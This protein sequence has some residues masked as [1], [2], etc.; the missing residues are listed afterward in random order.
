MSVADSKDGSKC[1][2]F[3]VDS[4]ITDSQ[5]D[6]PAPK[7]PNQARPRT[8]SDD[9]GILEKLGRLF[10]SHACP[11]VRKGQLPNC[12]IEPSDMLA[13]GQGDSS[14]DLAD[15]LIQAWSAQPIE[16]RKLWR[17]LASVF[18]VRYMGIALLAALAS[19][20]KV[21]S[22][23]VLGQF[24]RFLQSPDA[25]TLDG[26]VLG[27]VLVACMLIF[28]LIESHFVYRSTH[29]GINARVSVLSMMYAHLL[30]LNLAALPTAGHT[31]NIISNDAQRIEDGGPFVLFLI[32]APLE[33]L[34]VFGI[35]WSFLGPA[36]LAA[37]GAMMLIIVFLSSNARF[38]KRLR[39]HIVAAR[40]QRIKILSDMIK[41]IE[42]VKL[43]AWEQPFAKRVMEFRNQEM[44][45]LK[46]WYL[47]KS[48]NSAFFWS[49]PGC[50]ALAGF[51]VWFFA[52][53]KPLTSQLLFTTL[54]LFNSVR[55]NMGWRILR[56][57]EILADLKVSLN[58]I[59]EFLAIQPCDNEKQVDQVCRASTSP[60]HDAP[61]VSLRNASFSW[62]RNA[63][64]LS[65]IS[66][67]LRRGDFLGLI[68]PV[69][70][71]KSSLQ[72]ALL[73]HL[74]LVSPPGSVTITNRLSYAPQSPFIFAGTVRENILMG[75]P[76]DTDRLMAVVGVCQLEA[77]LTRW[78]AGLDTKLGDH[79]VKASGGQRARLA[80]AR[81]VYQDAEL[82]VLDDIFSA[83]DAAVANRIY[84][85]LSRYLAGRTVIL[86]SHQLSLIRR[87]PSVAYLNHGRIVSLGTFEQ[88]V[89]D[90]TAKDPDFAA[91]LAEYSSS[92]PPDHTAG[93]CHGP[94]HSRDEVDID[95]DSGVDDAMEWEET[96]AT[97]GDVTVFTRFIKMGG[98]TWL[99]AASIMLGFATSAFQA[100]AD[101]FLSQWSTVPAE[102]QGA[103]VHWMLFAAITV[104]VPIAAWLS[105]KGLFA[106]ILTT[107][108]S[109]FGKMLDNVM[110]ASPRFFLTR[111]SGTI[112]NRFSRDMAMIDE[113][114]PE[115]WSEVIRLWL[116]ILVIIVTVAIAVPHILL[117]VFPVVVIFLYLRARYVAANRQIRRL[118]ALSRS[119]VYSHLMLTVE[120][121]TTVTAMQRQE[122]YFERF[123]SLVDANT[124][125]LL[126]FFSVERWLCMRVDMLACLVIASA[127][128]LM[129]GLKSQL[130]IGLASLAQ[131]YVLSLVDETQYA[132]RKTAE[133]ELQFVSVERI[134]EY[135]EDIAL[136][137]SQES[138]PGKQPPANWPG[139]GV[140]EFRNMSL[141]YEGSDRPALEQI[142]FKTLPGESVGLCGRTGS[143]KSST[144]NALFRMA[145]P[146][147]RGSIIV[148][149]V[150]ICEI[151][152]HD[153]RKS[154]AI[155]PQSVF[156]FAG[157]VRFNLDPFDIHSE[158]ELWH[159]LELVEL[160][161]VVGRLPRKLDNVPA[162]S[163]GQGQLLQLARVILRKSKVVVLD[164]C[165]SNIDVA[166][167]RVLQRVIR[168][169]FADCTMLT[170]AHRCDT[171]V[172]ADRILMLDQGRILET[173]LPM[174]LLRNPDSAFHALA[175]QSLGK[176]K[177]AHHIS[178]VEAFD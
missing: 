73:G 103:S 66:L 89:Q 69:G 120:G 50:M 42:M 27:T 144:I 130:G 17:A 132:V 93:G 161:D 174:E 18:G 41:S 61:V 21:T 145:E 45:K 54:L 165:S 68:G 51:F 136:E 135:A 79:G 22:A 30:N 5:T 29:I 107:S 55:I 100:V 158:Q 175:R 19:S 95:G 125:S 10:F 4:V 72:L 24:I 8:Y 160:K 163:T 146:S 90:A 96:A 176:D 102:R 139:Q 170:I 83:L 26:I 63:P 13:L 2:L 155:I 14:R 74:H 6:D 3:V 40:D 101:F 20:C 77:D 91:V 153:L 122:M 28:A 110:R 113:L 70:S 86:V 147:P 47:F 169:N 141:T 71:G 9:R 64:V 134:L 151:G 128:G 82:Y 131:M 138:E 33:S 119:P 16:N 44:V 31:L 117:A 32:L 75:A 152:L 12:M 157:S 143:G 129:V 140:I 173:G 168:Q 133:L 15:R 115:A 172:G 36:S 94:G 87:C 59:E 150:D 156:I 142:S 178:S 109:V 88:V 65:G 48:V 57:V 148:D 76:E 116:Y 112:L 39:K 60:S 11:L 108:E 127:T 164:E 167:D 159:A 177:L 25:P 1:P 149:G 154:F 67:T 118:E 92:H 52:M 43:Y 80:L 84:D 114:L 171:I 78:D 85:S 81:A 97:G 38:L 121:I 56:A 53:G 124:R 62:D 123:C 166:T 46:Q 106:I 126:T 7:L 35:T 104:M 137:A 34:V 162:F 37:F 98:A 58:R 99:L 49:S 111:T 23:L 105:A